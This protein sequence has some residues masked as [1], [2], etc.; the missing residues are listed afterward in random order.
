MIRSNGKRNRKPALSRRRF[1]RTA[2]ISS[3]AVLLSGLPSGWR[4]AVWASDAPETT[5][6]NFGMIALTDCSPIIIAHERGLFKKY[7]INA[8]VTKGAS[9]AAL[10]FAGRDSAMAW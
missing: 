5:D 1:I 4:G 6:V 2:G 10:S 8:K 9:W 7:G 3:A